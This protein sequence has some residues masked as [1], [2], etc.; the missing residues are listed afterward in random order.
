MFAASY[1][2]P[3]EHFV[4]T[5]L[6]E[7]GSLALSGTCPATT[8]VSNHARVIFGADSTHAR[9]APNSGHRRHNP[10]AAACR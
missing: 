1:T 9:H 10:T 8:F 7:V 5:R 4:F 2:C 3:F 6:G